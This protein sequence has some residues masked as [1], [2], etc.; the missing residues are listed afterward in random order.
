M[1]EHT[2]RSI[3][4]TGV[5]SAVRTVELLEF[6]A[7]RHDQPARIREVSAA[8]DMP[9]SSAHAL[10]RT[11]IAQGWVRCDE[12]GTLYS[13][14]IRALLV[15][16]SYL[17]TDPYL[18]GITPFLDE[19][20]GAWDETFHLARLDG[21]DVVYLA[22]RESRQYQRTTNRVGRR[23]PAYT[24]AL[25]KALLAE[26]VGAERDAHIPTELTAITERTVTNRA[27]LDE[28]LDTA[29]IRGYATDDEENTVGVRCFAVPLRYSRP[30]Q[31]AIS[32]SV[33]V[34]RLT[35]DREVGL[36]EALCATGD[37]VS[38]VLRPLAEKVNS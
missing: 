27:A 32:V 2:V 1:T 35:A 19:L 4:G 5:K 33:P 8:L 16:T 38:R 7:A 30:V 10:L 15:G 26:R 20:R 12:S 28:A 37:K 18:P 3:T 25:G 13:I 11:L 9:R 29:R 36:I 23:L 17:D 22:T 21:Y 14:G 24:T 34:A 6:L 31:D